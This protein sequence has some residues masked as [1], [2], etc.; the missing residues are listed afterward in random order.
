[1]FKQMS[2][3]MQSFEA[4]HFP[5]DGRQPHLVELTTSPMTQIDPRTGQSVVVSILPHPEVHMD[6]PKGE[7]MRQ[8]RVQVCK[9]KL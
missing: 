8:W 3:D 9:T 7:Q 6:F 1:M 4:M 5:A 2:I